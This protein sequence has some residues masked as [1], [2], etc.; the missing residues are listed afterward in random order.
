V[1]GGRVS[2]LDVH[3]LPQIPVMYK[4]VIKGTTIRYEELFNKFYS[5]QINESSKIR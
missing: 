5:F 2:P 4:E 3:L 1:E